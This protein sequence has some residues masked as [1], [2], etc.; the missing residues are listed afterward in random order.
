MHKKTFFIKVWG[1]QMN[2]YDAD[3]IR[4]ILAS[5]GFMPVD[6]EEDANII[7]FQ[8]C[9]VRESAE[10]KIF[11]HISLLSRRKRQLKN[12]LIIGICGCMA[13]NYASSLN[14]KYPDI[15]IICGPN[16]YIDLPNLLETALSRG[17]FGVS[18]SED[19]RVAYPVLNPSAIKGFQGYVAVMRGCDNFCSYCIVPHVRGREKSR[20]PEEI[21][22]EVKGL[23]DNGVKDITLLGQNVNSYGKELKTDFASLL[24]L[25]NTIKGDFRLRFLTS[26]P[27][28]AEEK[29]FH[30]MA[31]CDKVCSYLHLPMQSG[32]NVIL[33][34]MNRKYTREKYFETIDLARRIVPD[35]TVSSDFIVGFPGETN[36]DFEKTCDAMR[37]VCYD[38]SFVFKYS[39]REGTD[40]A[41]LPDDVPKEVKEERNRVL[42]AL[43]EAISHDNNKTYLGKNLRILV[44]DK[45]KRNPER[46]FGRTENFKRV[47]FAGDAS[48]IGRIV[49]VKI[50]RVTA[51]TLFGE[52]INV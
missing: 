20:P 44:E 18:T 22:T 41:R 1:C 27:K 39:P 49:E 2:L 10:R 24:Y 4:D 42:L 36:D 37:R 7:L 14:K 8:T 23:V 26:H 33:E 6:N 28:D 15:D 30:A 31:E 40:A 35:L 45:S 9:S 32:S 12:G 29:L 52:Q 48:L 11:N 3:L 16:G 19:K 13:Q 21:Y 25:L 17:K 5:S 38:S 50:N 47:V 51:L 34:K 43:Q 46:L